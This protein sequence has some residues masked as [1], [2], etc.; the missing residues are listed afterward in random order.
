MT[1]LN[2]A[3]KPS[4]PVQSRVVIRSV[5]LPS[6]HGGWG[7]LLEPIVLGL[8]VAASWPGALLALAAC[9]VFLIHQPLKIAIKD[10]LKGQR[11]AR[12][13]WAER[14]VVGY[15]L[16]ALLPMLVLLLSAPLDFLLP[17]FIAMPLAAVQVVYDARNQSRKLLPELCGAAALAMIAPS[18]ALLASWSLPAA[19]A[20]SLPLIARAIT[21]I[22]YVRARL[23]LEHGKP[24]PPLPIWAVHAF[25]LLGV[26]GLA[27]SNVLPAMTVLAFAILAARAALGLSAYRKA[28][29]AKIIGFQEIGYGL[30]TV[31]LVS[32][33]YHLGL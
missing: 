28:R 22:L 4:Q 26:L 6:E 21:A 31:I 32:L 10:R 19:L 14:F 11:P 24:Q 27:L 12:T 8:L 13:L 16:M 15:G 3:H 20:L 25:A 2:E 1:T 29:P 17:V 7:F 23:R 18:L 33:G 30:L 5:A 9:G